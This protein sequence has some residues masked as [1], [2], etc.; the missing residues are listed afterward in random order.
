MSKVSKWCLKAFKSERE[1][2]RVQTSDE[3]IVLRKCLKAECYSLFKF[4]DEMGHSTCITKEE[5]LWLTLEF[6]PEK[7]ELI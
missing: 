3:M 7:L 1:I 5:A 6:V 2:W 4:N